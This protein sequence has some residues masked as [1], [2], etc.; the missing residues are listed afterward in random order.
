MIVVIEKKSN[1]NMMK[2]AIKRHSSSYIL[3]NQ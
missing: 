1:E 3:S 2:I